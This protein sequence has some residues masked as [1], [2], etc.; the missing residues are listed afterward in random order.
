[1]RRRDARPT[2][3]DVPISHDAEQSIAALRS[4][5]QEEE[6]ALRDRSKA[7]FDGKTNKQLE[8]AGVLLRKAKIQDERPT[9]FGKTRV[10]I[11]EDESRKGH[12]AGFDVR[13]G[14]V[15]RV[16]A[17]DD[18]GKVID[19]PQGVV[20]RRRFG[21]L[22]IV[23]DGPLE[24]VDPFA[25]DLVV[26]Q[27]EVT[28]RRLQDALGRANRAEKRA[29]KL[30]EALLGASLP[31]P[32]KHGALQPF[33]ALLH[34]DQRV[35]V[36]HGVYAEDIAL[37]HGPLG[38]GKTRVLVEVVR[39]CVAR[40]ERVLCLAASNAAVDH[41]ASSILEAD[42]TMRLARTGHPA[43]VSP[44]LEAHTLT[45]LTE[46]HE[47]RK[48]ARGLVEEALKL[49]S[50]TRRRSD[51][52]HDAYARR[53]EVKIE[54]NRLFAEA[55]K[56][57]RTAADDVLE[58]SRV[59]CGTLT[60]FA[61]E[62]PDGLV[63]DTAVVDEASQAITPAV[64]AG[65]LRAQRIVLAGDHKQLPPTVISRAKLLSQTVFAAL[66][67][68]DTAYEVSRMLRV[69]HRMHASLMEFPSTRFYAGAL[70]AHDLVKDRVLA[71]QLAAGTDDEALA[72]PAVVLDVVDCAGAG[73]EER[74]PDGSESKE[75]PGEAEIVA[76]VVR[77]LVAGGM[78]P[79][80]IGVISPYSG[81]VA[82]VGALLV[83][84]VEQGLEVDSVDGFQ[85]REKD[86]IVFSA[87]RSNADAVV[88][89]L[90]DQRRLNVALTRAKR[91]LVVVGDSATLSADDTWRAFFD[92]AVES[93]AHRSVFELPGELPVTS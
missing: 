87:V 33:D 4:A 11:V 45:A 51:R 24:D 83:D 8:A 40:G 13:E 82:H 25:V 32:T 75:N 69:Q 23:F 41:L 27:D 93:G 67:E 21:R 77:A 10:A 39:Q 74:S 54:A 37:V 49:L 88:G 55:R 59:V 62:L 91:K 31:K 15:V 6:Q 17:K 28:I 50:S 48:I 71:L 52:G 76:R 20:T 64:L 92:H 14:S 22:D 65:A 42:A 12:L 44:A 60:G 57:E 56:L 36:S 53:R 5:L 38:T 63:F 16:L 35:A 1:M 78:S 86:A 2:R 30:V 46:A 26:A 80:L 89:F 90:A 58:R 43:R 84:L 61:N 29:A 72:R 19:G 7:L 3:D 47:H 9:L 70:V 85:G 79:S 73:F 66:S 81:Q 68:Q 18:D 34:E